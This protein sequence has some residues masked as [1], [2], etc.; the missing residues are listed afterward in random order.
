[1]LWQVHSEKTLYAAPSAD[2]RIADVEL[3]DGRHR[4]HHLIRTTPAAGAVVTDEQDRVLLI[5]RHR[6]I[7]DSWGWEIPLGEV[8]EGE[9]PQAAAAREVEQKTGW[10]PGLLRPLLA[11]QPD[12]RLTDTLHY[13]YRAESATRLGPPADPWG[14]IDWLP[15]SGIRRLI[16][17][18]DIICGT[19]LSSLLYVALDC[20]G[21]EGRKTTFDP[22]RPLLLRDIPGLGL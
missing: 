11:V 9:M 15:M 21:V 17:N 2:V 4:D 3:P 5:W 8:V 22:T 7:T 6:F 1:M 18:G 12:N 19:T 13:V 16:D 14:R 10:R 20:L